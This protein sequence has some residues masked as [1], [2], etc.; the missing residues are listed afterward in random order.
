MIEIVNRNNLQ[1]WIEIL[2]ELTVSYGLQCLPAWE[3]MEEGT[4][5][6]I[7]RQESS[8]WNQGQNYLQRLTP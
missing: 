7:R 2:F 3:G 8:D 6:W 1:Q 5:G 4:C